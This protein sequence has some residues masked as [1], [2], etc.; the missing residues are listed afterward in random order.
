M[1]L[2]E[3]V[4]NFSE[5][6]D[7]STIDSICRA[8]T[9]VEGISLLD[10]DMGASTNRTVV[11]FVGPPDA[12]EE[13]A[14]LGI[15]RASELIDMARHKGSHPRMGAT[16]VVPFVPV[17]GVDMAGCVD[18]A[19]EVGRRVGDELGIPVY[20]YEHAA[21]S[22][23]RRSLAKVRAGEY[24]DLPKKLADP[25]WSPDF[26]PAKFNPTAGATA[27]GARGFLIAYNVTLN[28]RR[29]A[30]VRAMAER[31]REKG[32]YKRG[33]DLRRIKDRSGKFIPI[34]GKFKNVRAIGWYVD[35][36]KAAQVSINFTNYKVTPIHEVV[37]ELRRIAPEYGAVVTGSELVGLLPKDALLDA[38]RYYLT[39]Q[40]ASPGVPEPDLVSVAVRSLGL[41]D[42]YR[43][44][45]AEKVVEYRVARKSGLLVQ[46][47]ITG[48]VDEI[49]RDSAVPGGGSVAA[50]AGSMAAAL[51]GMV[52][53]LTI[54]RVKFL[55]RHPEM[56][57]IALRSQAIKDQLMAAVDRDSAAYAAVMTAM[58][59]PKKTPKEKATRMDAI[60]KATQQ[61]AAVPFSVLKALPEVVELAEVVAKAGNPASVSDA[62]VAAAMAGA[63]A[64]GACMNVLINLEGDDAP[65]SV[66]MAA[67][68]RL[69]RDRVLSAAQAIIDQVNSGFS[70]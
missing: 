12:V 27:I 66:K 33:T 39:G 37:Q 35:E 11:T 31:I 32:G 10:V 44:D 50:L 61:A 51:A 68:A 18:L 2:I 19:R 52:A 59:M 45:P 36:Y 67:E 40:G 46:K 47:T 1:Q 65:N 24:E 14:F 54:K 16:D 9:S 38:G 63:A 42:L 62:G 25:A 57:A 70:S 58:K 28:T 55:D 6:R 13:A 30:I 49:S 43:F 69:N 21:F 41:N 60:A 64:I 15:R 4:P 34:P 5:G 53:N 26:G 56:Q 8:I 20:M 7:K 22:D 17:S 29:V 3:C 23:E 48:F